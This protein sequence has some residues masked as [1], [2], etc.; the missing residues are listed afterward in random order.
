LFDG[1]NQSILFHP[2]LGSPRT[3]LVSFSGM[4]GAGKTT[5]IGE[6]CRR[7]EQDG[8][9]FR[10]ISFWDQVA[11]LTRVRESFSHTLFKGDKGV[12][13]PGRPLNRRDKNIQA[14][15]MTTLRYVLYLLDAASVW[16]VLQS[17]GYAARVVIFDRYVYDEL[18]NL[19]S[20]YGMTRVYVRLL[21]RITPRPDVAFLLDAD[22]VAARAR[23]PEYPLE[24]LYQNRASYLALSKS[25]GMTLIPPLPGAE[26]A[27]RIM[28]EVSNK[29]LQPLAQTPLPARN[30]A[31]RRAF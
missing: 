20:K 19:H 10:V 7:L 28:E 4:D 17:E 15:Y 31:Q 13:A 18:A 25:A 5:Q 9:S 14:W 11:A 2:N 23:K 30:R 1:E 26:A 6:L 29:L 12:G 24:F 8:I 3:L 16:R 21:L 22:P 27:S